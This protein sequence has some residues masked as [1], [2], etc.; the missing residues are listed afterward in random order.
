MADSGS[1]RELLERYESSHK[2]QSYF[3]LLP[4]IYPRF[5]RIHQL[6]IHAPQPLPA[7]AQDD[8][9]APPPDRGVSRPWPYQDIA[10]ET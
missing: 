2:G 6:P 8:L 1:V 5:L 4:R 9:G 3:G 7:A 10:Q